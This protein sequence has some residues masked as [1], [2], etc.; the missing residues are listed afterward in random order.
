MIHLHS[1]DAFVCRLQA[2]FTVFWS[3]IRYL[4]FWKLRPLRMKDREKKTGHFSECD[5]LY[6]ENNTGDWISI[7]CCLIQY[8]FYQ[9][10]SA[11]LSSES[12]PV[13]NTDRGKKG[14][15]KREKKIKLSKNHSN[16]TLLNK[17]LKFN[18][19]FFFFY[20]FSLAMALV[21]WR[22][23]VAKVLLLFVP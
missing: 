18:F 8:I 3:L 12:H 2:W 9:N 14:L 21:M 11:P 20:R 22:L 19:S 10:D 7:L 17:A 16:Q 4:C 1:S 23:T 15:N 6:G 5:T 13:W